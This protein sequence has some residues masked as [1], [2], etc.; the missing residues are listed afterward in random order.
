MPR[1]LL[2]PIRAGHVR[3]DGRGRGRRLFRRRPHLGGR[4]R[5]L[6]E[7][8]SASNASVDG[9]QGQREIDLALPFRRHDRDFMVRAEFFPGARHGL[10]F[11]VLQREMLRQM[12]GAQEGDRC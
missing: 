10:R 5:G 7:Q 3:H 2:E 1:R 4:G 12:A 9:T 8:H 6:A 11:A